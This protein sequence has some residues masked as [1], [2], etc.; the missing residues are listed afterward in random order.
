MTAET[1]HHL[2]E[3]SG[4]DG[5]LRARRLRSSVT[6]IVR[7]FRRLCSSLIRNCKI[8]SAQIDK[9]VKQNEKITQKRT[10]ITIKF[11]LHIQSEIVSL[12]ITQW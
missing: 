2:Q 11:W 6:S 9:E 10:T 12:Q 1:K 3:W 4:D 5:V 8:K 7:S